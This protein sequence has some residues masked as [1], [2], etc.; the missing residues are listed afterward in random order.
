MKQLLLLTYLIGFGLY[1]QNTVFDPLNSDG[2]LWEYAKF[3]N[4]GK[5]D[6][7]IDEVLKN[8]SFEYNA[9]ESENHSV[10]F[11]SNNYWV[12]FS[13]KNSTNETSTYY[14]ETARPVTDIA[15]LFQIGIN[16]GTQHF[17]SGDKIPFSERQ[18]KHRA[19]V[20]KIEQPANT[21]QEF[22]LH[23]KSDGET[24]NL[25]L[26]L[27][28]ASSFWMMNYSQQL[29]LG[30]FYGL[31]FLAGIIYLFFYTSLREKSF[32]YYGFYV[33]SIAFMQ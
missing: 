7:S 32:L 26:N 17:K 2:S 16:G 18:V 28:T 13:L 22:Y 23:F 24:L 33:F 6:W 5:N 8:A 31:L 10:G 11:T 9:L 25:P 1:A 30:L 14:L 19:T 3:F 21:T 27:Y 20:F 4:A 29:F 12:R 15:N